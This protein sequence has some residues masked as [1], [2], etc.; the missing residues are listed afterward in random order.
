MFKDALYKKNLSNIEP[1]SF[2]ENVAA[3]FDNMINRSVPMY[4][5]LQSIIVRLVNHL[6]KPGFVVYDLGCSTGE[7]IV[8][9]NKKIKQKNI[10][11][12]G[13]D[14]SEAMLKKAK[15]KCKDIE[16]VFFECNDIQ[17]IEFKKAGIIIMNYVLQFI[18][19]KFRANLLKNIYTNLQPGGALL[20]SEKIKSSVLNDVFL[21]AHE[22]FKLDNSYSNLEIQQKR[23]SLENVLIT[24]TVADNVKL[25]Q[26]AGFTVIEKYFQYLN[27]CGFIALKS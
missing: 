13:V 3:V 4:K 11:I 15:Y 14:S 5:E 22:Q 17:K 26:N 1:F 12:V 16:D 24:L 6:Y 2:N 10:Q 18:D 25:L 23:K 21:T 20:L 8:Q 9:I 7:T 27:F 19:P